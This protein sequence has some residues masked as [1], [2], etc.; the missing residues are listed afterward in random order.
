[1]GDV[2]LPSGIVLALLD[3]SSGSLAYLATL[4]GVLSP[5]KVVFVNYVGNDGVFYYV[6]DLSVPSNNLHLVMHRTLYTSSIRIAGN[7]IQGKA[8]AC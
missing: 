8:I 6:S 1:M 4:D 3:L 7:G 5:P 2:C